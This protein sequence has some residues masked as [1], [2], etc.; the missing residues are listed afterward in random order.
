MNRKSLLNDALSKGALLG[1][2]MLASGIFEQSIFL[3]SGSIGWIVAVGIEEI[4]IA[5]V[6]V[7]L[8]YRYTK[9][10]AVAVY[11]S[12]PE[13]KYFTF[14]E[15]LLYAVSL[16]VLAG[17]IASLGGYLYLHSVI[18]YNEYVAHMTQWF[19]AIL[20]SAAPSAPALSRNAI[21]Q[22]ANTPEPSLV[23]TVLSGM[24]TYL[25]FG[26][27]VGSFIA[28]AVRRHPTMNSGANEE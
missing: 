7:W 16:S 23:Q 10:A 4:V 14:G 3:H 1:I 19:Q 17:I 13:P 26:T 15:G 12:R 21:A 24:F 2:I 20:A 18:G 5:V 27:I 6:Y 22:I 9:K 28:R 8:L 11:E 25:I